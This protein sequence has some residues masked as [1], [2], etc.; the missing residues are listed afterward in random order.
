VL[1]IAPRLRQRA[2]VRRYTAD[3]ESLLAVL[4]DARG[5]LAGTSAARLLGWPLPDGAWP[6]E[7]YVPETA[8]VDVTDEYALELAT[9]VALRAVPDPWPFQPHMRV[10]PELVAVLDLAEAV[11]PA[12]TEVGRVR[13]KELGDGLE[14]S[15]ERRPPRRRPLRS[16]VPAMPRPARTGSIPP[17][18]RPC[19]MTEPSP[20]PVASSPCCSWPVACAEP[21]S[22][23][24]CTSRRAASNVLVRS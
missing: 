17:V 5:V 6:V 9:D 3:A 8:L 18:L 7:L 21:S 24:R 15:W 2:V 4:E 16:S 20:M 12:L 14:P 19:G 23:K 13:L 11:A 10:V 22:P 1:E